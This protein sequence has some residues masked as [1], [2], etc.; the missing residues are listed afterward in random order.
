[1]G[2]KIVLGILIFYM[3]G[4]IASV[5]IES[6]L[7]AMVLFLFILIAFF[8]YASTNSS[9]KRKVFGLILITFFISGF[10]ITFHKTTY[11]SPFRE[12][13]GRIVEVEG[14]ISG[15]K[16]YSNR[17][18]YWLKNPVVY[19]GDDRV[20]GKRQE[21]IQLNIYEPTF[22]FSYGTVVR[23]RE[24]LREA[25]PRR[26]P[27]GFDYQ[28]FLEKRNIFTI[29]HAGEHQVIK[30]G[31]RSGN[32]LLRVG[33]GMKERFS[34][35]S[36]TLID[37]EGGIFRALILGETSGLVPEDRDVYQ[38]IGV[39]HIFAVSGLHVGFVMSLLF[40][41]TSFFR[42][43][44]SSS[45]KA[46]PPSTNNKGIA[47]RIS[48][49]LESLFS[50]NN[51][52]NIFIIVCLLIYCA[53]IGFPSP[54]MRASIMLGIY[55]WGRENWNNV[56]TANSLILAALVLLLLNPLMIFDAGFQLTFIATAFIIFLT[57]I[58]KA[59]KYFNKDWI[60]VPLAAWLGTVPLI[61]YYFNIFAPLGIVTAI[62]AGYMAGGAVIIGFIAFILDFISPH[63]SQ[64]LMTSVGG[65]I[66]YSN[67][68]LHLFAVLPI[69][70][71]GI[72]IATPSIPTIFLYYF[73]FILICAAYH[74]RYNPHLKFF[75]LKNYKPVIAL[76][77]IC[78]VILLSFQIFTPSYLE[79]VFLDV[80][81]GDCVLIRTPNGRVVLID[82][83]GIT[84]N[85]NYGDLVVVPFLRHLGIRKVDVI[86]STH[87]HTDH[88]AGLYPVLRQ[89]HV[90]LVLMPRGFN[91][92]YEYLKEI[93]NERG[94]S[95][96]YG[97][98]GQSIM[99]EPNIYL[100]VI[101]PSA[102]Y[103]L[104]RGVNN[105]SLVTE[106]VFNNIS[107]LFTG[108]IEMDAMNYML[109]RISQSNVLQF[110][111]HGSANTSFHVGYL[112]RVDPE[113]VVIQVGRNNPFGHPGRIILEYFEDRGV[114][115]YR[116]D[117]HGA[118]TIYSRGQEINRVDTVIR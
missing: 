70:G 9:N 31:E 75:M 55:L 98:M 64:F 108:D 97:L 8:L 41:A 115:I 48:P 21:R 20:L 60:A 85:H 69:V 109:P 93:L 51:I 37:H 107:L 53:A 73:A 15:Y 91:E 63:L 5:S 117:L 19:V 46:P 3:L 118:I 40:A 94:I 101:H 100:N 39:M 89:Y 88:L 72:I 84:G 34:E 14:M 44:S 49:L 23:V 59:S 105:H 95:Y 1:M 103:P 71:E 67:H 68:I 65:I 27:G 78:I 86:I 16:V 58:L 7:L 35:L 2:F 10:L 56:Q 28:K 32:P 45:A 4:T 54:V 18:V 83:G 81:Q 13:T 106:L 104:S 57:P 74:H 99:L 114:P 6:L 112:E 36:Y 76:V 30:V 90:D 38:G 66:F 113:I 26:N 116:N 11:V 110:P 102:S 96:A 77:L 33:L 24:V 12:H 111:H 25:S 43:P 17:T 42:K 50:T 22:N 79:V 52:I 92:G 61:A 47:A 29:I 82:G 62:P 80:G 87:Y